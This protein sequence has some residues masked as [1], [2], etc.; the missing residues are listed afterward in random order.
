MP[1]FCPLLP[2]PNTQFAIAL[3]SLLSKVLPCYQHT[4]TRRTS[5]HSLGTFRAAKFSDSPPPLKIDEVILTPPPFSSYSISLSVSW[6]CEEFKMAFSATS[7][8]PNVT[9]VILII[10]QYVQILQLRHSEFLSTKFVE[11]TASLGLQNTTHIGTSCTHLLTAQCLQA[12]FRYRDKKVTRVTW[13]RE[14]SSCSS[15]RK[16]FQANTSGS[17]SLSSVFCYVR[18]YQSMCFFNLNATWIQIRNE[19]NLSQYLTSRAATKHMVRI[20][21]VPSEPVGGDAGIKKR[22]KTNHT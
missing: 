12:R 7:S 18:Q 20:W 8:F 9:P 13:I 17:I 21:T 16:G 3:P 6:E 19:S 22:E 5:G 4:F 2:I 11:P 10:Q 14:I 1:D 15:I